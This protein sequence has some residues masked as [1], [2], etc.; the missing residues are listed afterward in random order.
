MIEIF[1]TISNHMLKGLMLHAQWA[2]MFDFLNLHGF[3]RQQEYQFLSESAEM[4][5]L[6][7]YAINHCNKLIKDDGVNVKEIPDNWYTATRFDVDNNTRK[8][9][10]KAIFKKWHDWETETKQVYEAAFKT[11][12]TNDKIADANKL[13][14]LIM[15]VDKE[16]KT[17]TREMLE[18]EAVDWDMDYILWKQQELHEK[19]KEKECDKLN[20]N[21]T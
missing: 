4:R 2:D 15:K 10:V 9:Y 8:N 17:L 5:G 20:I 11:L 3:K 6:H 1:T 7:R 21:I 18:Y 13:N 12:S 14:D 19:Y 16:L